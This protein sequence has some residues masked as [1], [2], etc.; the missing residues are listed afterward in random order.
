M[1]I[2][3]VKWKDHPVLGNLELD[4]VNPSTGVVYDNI[5]FAGENGTGKTKI[6]TTLNSFL[7]I[8]SFSPFEYIEYEFIGVD[9]NKQVYRAIPYQ[10]DNYQDGFISLKKMPD[11]DVKSLR[12]SKK[13][14]VNDIEKDPSDPRYYGCVMSKA[15]ASF[16][17]KGINQVP[18]QELDKIIHDT[19]DEADYTALMQLLID[20]DNEDA[21]AYR[22]E[23]TKRKDEGL[24]SI[25][26]EDYNPQTKLYRFSEAFKV[27]FNEDIILN[28]VGRKNVNQT[29]LFKKNECNIPIDSLSTG[30]KQ[31]VFRG[32]YLLRNLGKLNGAI[33]MV[34]EPE[35]SMHPKWQK[36]ILG[37][38]TGLFKEGEKK[39]EEVKDTRKQIA[40]MFFATHSDHVVKSALE[41]IANSTVIILNED[42]GTVKAKSI[43]VPMILPIVTSGEVN[44][45]A[46]DIPSIDYHTSLYGY[47]QFKIGKEK[48]LDTDT[49]ITKQAAY[50][51]GKHKKIT[52]Y[53]TTT[54]QTICTYV[55]N[56]IDHPDP[57]VILKDEDI[58]TSIELLIELIKAIP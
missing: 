3:K 40:Q 25:T 10:G 4:F 23:N 8:G 24:A 26:P 57:L 45:M 36:K 49:Y 39:E 53:K 48:V 52:K 41:E 20:L 28:S 18:T 9:G 19:D 12:R 6:L 13:I 33:I 55:R 2:R 32:A 7:C 15:K 43:N 42:N 44:Y 14:N 58:R 56:Q 11:G 16:N 37:Y 27:I 22:A 38:Y 50:D 29:V 30:E 35:I 34:D 51:A 47:L 21:L 17:T 31:I 5:V 46:Y 54:Y 1:K